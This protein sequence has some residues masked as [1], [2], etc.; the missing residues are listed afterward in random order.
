[1]CTEIVSGSNYCL[2]RQSTVDPDRPEFC[3]RY[4]N[5]CVIVDLPDKNTFTY[6]AGGKFDSSA[7]VKA[8]VVHAV[9]TEASAKTDAIK[10]TA[11]KIRGSRS[12]RSTRGGGASNADSAMG[13]SPSRTAH[14][15]NQVASPVSAQSM[16]VDDET[17]SVVTEYTYGGT[18]RTVEF[19]DGT[20]ITTYLREVPS[21][22]DWVCFAVSGYRYSHPSYGQPVTEDRNGT[23]SVPGLVS[24]SSDG[25]FRLWLG[26]DAGRIEVTSDAVDVYGSKRPRGGSYDDDDDPK[27]ATFGWKDSA[28]LF[29]KRD[30]RGNAPKQT[31]VAYDGTVAVDGAVAA[32]GPLSSRSRPEPSMAYFIVK[33]NMSGFRVLDGRRYNEFAEEIRDR[34][35][36]IV[37][38]TRAEIVALS[39]EGDTKKSSAVDSD[40][41]GW[42]T[43]FSGQK[44]IDKNIALSSK[45]LTS[46]TFRR[47]NVDYGPVLVAL[48]HVT[49]TGYSDDEDDE[50]LP[51]TAVTNRLAVRTNVLDYEA[52]QAMYA[53]G[54]CGSAC[55]YVSAGDKRLATKTLLSPRIGLS[56]RLARQNKHNRH[57]LEAQRLMKL[58]DFIPF[59]HYDSYEPLRKYFIANKLSYPP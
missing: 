47:A 52:V 29:D 51:Q 6:W 53:R 35:H 34:T 12:A 43:V 23:F 16:A 50:Q 5:G 1:M 37:H 8:P 3:R 40:G 44:P 58:D 11:S 57:A 36:T 10:P 32:G 42:L 18:V 7:A 28:L 49:A 9:K 21:E 33:R 45:L 13:K 59:F 30:G 20:R 19:E 41:F 2:L 27:I 25:G 46:R 17:D 22:P 48:S 55:R 15:E 26:K 24:R 56:L 39:V 54:L 38:E 4:G 14:R 31:T